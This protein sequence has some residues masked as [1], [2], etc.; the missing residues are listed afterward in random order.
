ME[1]MLLIGGILTEKLGIGWFGRL[2]I[3]GYFDTIR[4]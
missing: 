3:S 1:Q 4:L 2:G